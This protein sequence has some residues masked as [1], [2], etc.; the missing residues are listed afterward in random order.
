[1]LIIIKN[2][3]IA[4]LVSYFDDVGLN[5]DLYTYKRPHNKR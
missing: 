3:K 1:M 5:L 2:S 4:L